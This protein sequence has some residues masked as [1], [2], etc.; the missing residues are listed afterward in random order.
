MTFLRDLRTRAAARACTLVFPEAA[1]ARTARAIAVLLRDHLLTPLAVGDPEE[2]REALH[3][4]GGDVGALVIQ[5]PS[6]PRVLDRLAPILAERRKD[7][8]LGAEEAR[9]L[10]G[11]PLLSAGLAVAAGDAGG[12]VAGAVA[13]TSQVIRAGLWCLGVA[14]ELSTVS[15]AFYMVVPPF[16][17]EATEVL[18]FTDAGVVPHPTSSQLAEIGVAAARA[19]VLVVGDEPRVAFL[20]YSTMGSASGPSIDRVREAVTRFRELAPDVIVDGELQGD[21]ALVSSVAAQKSPGSSLAG[22][23]N[24]LVFPDLDAGNIAYKLVQRLVGCDALGPIVQGLRRPFN[25]LSRG[26]TSEEIVDVA[27]ITALMAAS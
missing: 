23:A 26:C 1:E 6:D 20:S 17:S 24:V 7:K 14:P 18:T 21:A 11:D 12:A 13:A 8:G 4:A 9:V 5:D 27:C 19:R 2:V 25:D 16:R 3:Q 22:R 10:A 15:S